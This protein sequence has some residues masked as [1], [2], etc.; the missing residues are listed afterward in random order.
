[1]ASFTFVRHNRWSTQ[2][3]WTNL[4]GITWHISLRLVYVIEAVSTVLLTMHQLPEAARS[5]HSLTMLTL[6]MKAAR[7]LNPN[8]YWQLPIV[9]GR[10]GQL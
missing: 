9:A 10:R 2:V 1:M 8:R 7:L 4:A 5:C 6:T 3:A